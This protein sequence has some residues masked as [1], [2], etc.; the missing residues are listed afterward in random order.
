MDPKIPFG[1]GREPAVY[2]SLIQ[3]VIAAL[4][5][6]EVVHWSDTQTGTILAVS[7]G[8]IGLAGS[9]VTDHKYVSSLAFPAALLGIL[10]AGL[11]LA[12]A[13]GTKVTPTQIGAI[14]SVAALAFSY[15]WRQTVSPRGLN[16]ADVGFDSTVLPEAPPHS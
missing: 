5:A 3:A 2:L 14:M 8:V 13:F 7:A 4:V 15:I 12:L 1:P 10:Q 16:T 9:V 6:F 11:S